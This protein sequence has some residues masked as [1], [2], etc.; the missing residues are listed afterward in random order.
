MLKSVPECSATKIV[1]RNFRIKVFSSK[2][3]STNG[4]LL[5]AAS[6]TVIKTATS[7]CQH[8]IVRL[9]PLTTEA[10][11]ACVSPLAARKAIGGLN[12]V[13]I[14]DALK[15]VDIYD[16]K[17]VTCL[18]APNF[19]LSK[20]GLAVATLNGLVYAIG[21][22]SCDLSANPIPVAS[23]DYDLQANS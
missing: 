17:T 11:L 5:S 3:L 6:N 8:R 12:R 18:C 4:D 14:S 19:V 23:F 10:E 20:Y 16:I 2:M 7:L 13:D 21:E 15:G 1:L 22:V 9:T